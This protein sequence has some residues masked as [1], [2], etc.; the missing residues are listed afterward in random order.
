VLNYGRLFPVITFSHRITETTQWQAS[1]TER[2]TRPPINTIAPAFFF[3]G[4]DNIITGNPGIRPSIS[5]QFT[6][7]LQ[8]KKFLFT[9]QL[10]K[11]DRPFT[12]Q[13]AFDTVNNVV[14]VKPEN[15]KSLMTEMFS[16]NYTAR[17]KWWTSQYNIAAY[18]QQMKP[19]LNDEIIN[20]KTFYL[21][22]NTT[23]G[24]KLPPGYTIELSSQTITGHRKGLGKVPFVTAF[25]LGLQKTFSKKN[26]VAL[27]WTDMFN[28]GSFF[29][30]R[31][32]RS[33]F[34]YYIFHDFEGSVFKL[35]FVHSFGNA[36]LKKSDIRKT[37]SEDEVKR[38]N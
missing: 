14:L 20:R 19:L 1:Y 33:D 22:F 8:M 11:E 32:L 15:M 35:S 24:I 38:V 21:A 4:P 30:Y 36:G 37:A 13:P 2:I 27:S 17:I 6:S 5:H 18:N 16:V 3:F 28:C 10:S 7:S 23:Q 34:D 26:K 31:Q 12:L 9:L 25:N 29:K